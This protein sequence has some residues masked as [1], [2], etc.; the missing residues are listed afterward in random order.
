MQTTLSRRT[1]LAYGFGDTGFS[2]T[3]TVIAAYFAIFLTDV[4]GIAPAT[5]AIAERLGGRLYK[6]YR[7]YE[8]K[9]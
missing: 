3:A 1:R 7:V 5:L 9:L 2:L 8:L 4:V 6:R